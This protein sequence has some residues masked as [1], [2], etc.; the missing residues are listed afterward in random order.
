MLFYGYIYL[1]DPFLFDG[2]RKLSHIPKSIALRLT[3]LKYRQYLK[4]SRHP[5]ILSFKARKFRTILQYLFP[6]ESSFFGIIQIDVLY[7]D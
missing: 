1:Q 4:A 6:F 3:D 2:I 5:I 7:S